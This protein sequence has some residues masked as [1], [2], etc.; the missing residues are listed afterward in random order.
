MYAKLRP[1]QCFRCHFCRT[2][3]RVTYGGSIEDRDEARCLSC[4]VILTDWPKDV[5]LELV[6]AAIPDIA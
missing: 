3:Y 5:G 6:E 1:G 2:L 4:G